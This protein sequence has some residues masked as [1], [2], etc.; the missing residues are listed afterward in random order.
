[1]A[2]NWQGMN[3]IRPEKR[4]AIYLRDGMACCWC[5]T[6]VETE[7]TILTLD[8]CRPRCKGGGNEASNLITACKACNSARGSKTLKDFS[9]YVIEKSGRS[10]EDT[11]RHI[12]N[13]RKR[14]LPSKD[15]IEEMKAR[16]TNIV[17]D[18]QAQEA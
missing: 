17:R 5:G 15:R 9:E 18:C 13:C 14:I 1:M 11:L 4:L 2:T 8:H 7:G 6:S 12:R 3:W 10:I 16:R